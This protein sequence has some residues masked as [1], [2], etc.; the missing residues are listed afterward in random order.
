MLFSIRKFQGEW[1]DNWMD[2]YIS[3][4]QK[5]PNFVVAAVAVVFIVG[6]TVAN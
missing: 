2:A 6:L 5:G 4:T 1:L 3:Y